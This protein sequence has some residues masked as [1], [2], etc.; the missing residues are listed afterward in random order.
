M[1][2]VKTIQDLAVAVVF[3]GV[4]VTPEAVLYFCSPRRK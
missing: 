2:I 3:L 4:A 1:E